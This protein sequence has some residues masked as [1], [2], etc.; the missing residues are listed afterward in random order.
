MIN[1][2]KKIVFNTDS[3]SVP[4]IPILANYFKQILVI[5]ARHPTMKY[6]FRQII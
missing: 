3:M 1:N 2:N 6:G 4:V 5:D